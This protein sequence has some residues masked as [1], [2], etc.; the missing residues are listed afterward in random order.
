MGTTW[1]H[2]LKNFFRIQIMGNGIMKKRWERVF[3]EL[4]SQE[5]SGM[6]E[7]CGFATMSF[8]GLF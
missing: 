4:F 6:A 5:E 3:E 7:W 1:L 8:E 2:S